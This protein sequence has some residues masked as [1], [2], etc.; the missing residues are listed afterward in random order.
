[1]SKV[2]VFTPENRLARFFEDPNGLLCAHALQR[3]TANLSA[4]RPSLLAALDLKLEALTA[5][6]ALPLSSEGKTLIY[7][8]AEDLISDAGAVGLEDLSR[9]AHSLC[10]LLAGDERGANFSAA[11]HVHVAALV[12]LRTPA[13]AADRPRRVAVL[14]GLV[15]LSQKSD[16]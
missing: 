2:R 5:Q 14:A 9:A 4:A 13:S 3:A 6:A 12:A 1:M 10:D 7:R 8:L 15:R 16:P 11:L